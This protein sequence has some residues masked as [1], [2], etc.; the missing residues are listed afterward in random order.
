MTLIITTLTEDLILQSADRRISY[1]TQPDRG[2]DGPKFEIELR[3][4]E[5]SKAVV[6]G[7]TALAAYTGLATLPRSEIYTQLANRKAEEIDSGLWLA[8]VIDLQMR[9]GIPLQES[10]SDT[11]RVLDS[12]IPIDAKSLTIMLASWELDDL[13]IWS[14]QILLLANAGQDSFDSLRI[15]LDKKIGHLTLMSKP[16]EESV[17]ADF[18]NRIRKCM[19]FGGNASSLA[20]VM[21]ETTRQAAKFDNTIGE[22]VNITCIPRRHVVTAQKNE[23]WE[24]GGGSINNESMAFSLFEKGKKTSAGIASSPY[25]LIA[26]NIMGQ[27]NIANGGRVLVNMA[28]DL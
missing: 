19:D 13:H 8:E 10:T 27:L 12:R 18:N 20:R 7:H 4:D 24:L 25:V 14:P 23:K 6:V 22:N 16:I 3:D 26:G 9:T 5:T 2:E 28:K 17:Q 11:F 21:L 15:N 1:V